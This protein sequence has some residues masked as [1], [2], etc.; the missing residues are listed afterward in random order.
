M[1]FQLSASDAPAN[2]P[3]RVVCLCK[4]NLS[5]RRGTLVEAPR[6][7]NVRMFRRPMQHRATT[8]N[9]ENIAWQSRVRT[10]PGGRPG[11][12]AAGASATCLLARPLCVSIC[13]CLCLS[14]ATRE[15]PSFVTCRSSLPL[16]LK[17]QLVEKRANCPAF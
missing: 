8:S 15:R 17:L 6:S 13:L 7:S 1:S 12:L 3:F 14:R 9:F 4:V 2:L 16:L 10:V 11:G 5:H